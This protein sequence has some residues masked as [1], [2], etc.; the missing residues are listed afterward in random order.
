M[1]LWPAA[2]SMWSTHP[3]ARSAPS[4]TATLCSCKPRRPPT[5]PRRISSYWPARAGVECAKSSTVTVQLTDLQEMQNHM[6]ETIDQGLQDL[7]A[8]QGTGGLASSSAICAGPP[9]TAAYAAAAPPPEAN[10]SAEIAQADQQSEQA[11]KDV[12]AEAA[13]PDTGAPS[14]V[15]AAAAAAPPRACSAHGNRRAWP[16]H[17]PGES[18]SRHTH[19]NRESGTQG[20]LLLQRH[21]GHLQRRQG[22]R[23]PVACSTNTVCTLKQTPTALLRW[24]FLR[25]P[26]P[27]VTQGTLFVASRRP[28]H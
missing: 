22:Q 7:Q 27:F 6:R 10:V 4:A 13:Q 14:P 8:K 2:A 19:T 11:E 12:T 24:A 23:R 18:G 20:H 26:P 28:R 1:S 3:P 9:A 21:E 15:A 25:L 16:D 5:R 17:G